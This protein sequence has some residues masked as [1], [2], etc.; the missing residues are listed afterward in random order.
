M[1]KKIRIGIAPIAWTND[2]LPDLGSENTF[3]QC[4][5]EMALAGYEGTEIGN[6]YPKDAEALKQALELRGLRVC[7]AW[8]SASFT[9]D[10][11]EEVLEEFIRHR[12]F[13]HAMGAE[14]IG[15][16]E[17]GD[18]IQ[19]EPLPIFDAKPVYTEAEW[20]KVVGGFDAMAAL[21]KDKG[22]KLACHHHMGTGVQS[23]D[24]VERFMSEVSDDVWLLYDSGHIFY[25]E[26]GYGVSAFDERRGHDAC[27]NLLQKYMGRIAHIHFK[28]VRPD[29]I[30]TVWDKGLSF[31][32]GVRA[33]SFTVPGDGAIDFAPIAR[34]IM[35]S[36]YDGWI[37]VEAEQDPAKADPLRYAMKAKRYIDG[38][39]G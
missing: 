21:A 11:K 32:D 24:E 33:G 35:V 27:L 14:I 23:M 17:V 31:L 22:M 38:I 1:E 8:F 18:S 39:L 13:L 34:E 25:S 7:N 20:S 16:A 12:D 37:V 29:V 5:S 19:G 28:D 30:R 15:A 36:G 6:K 26:S 4:V 2:D 10:S 9:T 3:E